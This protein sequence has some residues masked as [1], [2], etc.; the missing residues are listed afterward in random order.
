MNTRPFKD[1]GDVE[2]TAWQQLVP[3]VEGEAVTFTFIES[4]ESEH[5]LPVHEYEGFLIRYNGGLHA[6]RNSCPHMGSPLDWLPGQFFSEGG[7]QLVCHTHDARF[8]PADGA[9]ISG[10]CPHGLSELPLRSDGRTVEVP[11]ALSER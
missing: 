9:C 3:P 10:P 6:Y 8:N 7:N 2:I 1:S 11:S 5:Q 4:I